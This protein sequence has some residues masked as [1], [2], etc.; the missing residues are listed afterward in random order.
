MLSCDYI[1]L[2]LYNFFN[3]LFKLGEDGIHSQAGR[4]PAHFGLL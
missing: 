4:L 3:E 1:H 2:T